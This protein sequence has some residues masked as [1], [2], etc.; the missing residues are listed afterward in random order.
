MKLTYKIAKGGGNFVTGIVKGL[1]AMGGVFA[2]L[3][4]GL[5]LAL[6]FTLLSSFFVGMYLAFSASVLFGLLVLLIEPSASIIG[7]V[8]IFTGTDLAAKVVQ[9]FHTLN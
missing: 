3:G 9:W 2:I 5:F 8:Y 4:V 7:M 1:L 6:V